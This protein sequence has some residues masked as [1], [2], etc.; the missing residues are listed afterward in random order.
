MVLEL[1]G[2]LDHV[3]VPTTA[4]SSAE[5]SRPGFRAQSRAAA[6]MTPAPAAMLAA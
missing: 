1:T 6:A 4:P 2:M 5:E 3:T